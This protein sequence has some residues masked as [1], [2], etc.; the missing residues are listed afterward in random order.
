MR[1]IAAS[2]PL[3]AIRRAVTLC[4]VVA[5]IAI[6]GQA[7]IFACIHYTTVR[8]ELGVQNPLGRPSL[9]VVGATPKHSPAAADTPEAAV[10]NKLSRADGVLAT[11]SN[12]SSGLGLIALLVFTSQSWMAV[13]IGAGAGVIGIQRAVLA[14]SLAVAMLAICIPWSSAIPA[15]PIWGVF[16][17]YQPLVLASEAVRSGQRDELAVLCVHVLLPVAML[18]LIVW[19]TTALRAGISAG[20]LSQ[21]IDPRVEAEIAAVQEHGAGSLHV[22]RAAREIDRAMA[23][24]VALP[25]PIRAEKEAEKALA[26]L[27]KLA[28]RLA[29]EHDEAPSPI[30]DPLRR[31]I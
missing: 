22:S 30:G 26:D 14:S 17:G 31:P 28:G 27:E 20:I 18:G 21:E 4:A 25:V 29:R 23:A 15:A 11:L 7:L 6:I 10:K 12:V 8:Y 16:C 24:N 2:S 19:A 9:A 3:L 1:F 13:A 5:A